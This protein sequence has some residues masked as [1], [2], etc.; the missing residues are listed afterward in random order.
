MAK[1]VDCRRYRQAGLETTIG[2]L[3][4]NCLWCAESEDVVR[5]SDTP[6]PFAELADTVEQMDGEA[7]AEQV[8]AELTDNN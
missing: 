1:C 3:C 2:W 6:A 8:D 4:D 7:L 5:R